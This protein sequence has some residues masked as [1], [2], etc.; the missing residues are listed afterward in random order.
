MLGIGHYTSRSVAPP[1]KDQQGYFN[2]TLEELTAM[3]Q[4]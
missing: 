1:K 3:V 4:Q 2:S